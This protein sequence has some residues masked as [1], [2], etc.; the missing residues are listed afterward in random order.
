[1]D[2][3]LMNSDDTFKETATK[4]FASHALRPT[5][6][7]EELPQLR[8]FLEFQAEK[9]ERSNTP[10]NR[11]QSLFDP[12]LLETLTALFSQ[13]TFISATIRDKHGHQVTSPLQRPAIC[14]SLAATSHCVGHAEAMSCMAPNRCFIGRC[15]CGFLVEASAVVQLDGDLIA[16]MALGGVTSMDLDS[17]SS[18]IESTALDSGIDIEDAHRMFEKVV[19]LSPAKVQ[20]AA[21]S[22]L[23]ICQF[24]SE[25]ASVNYAKLQTARAHAVDERTR[26]LLHM[27]G[28]PQG[29][30]ERLH[31]ALFA[32]YRT[33]R[34]RHHTV[35][36]FLMIL[37]C[38][39]PFV[40]G[41]AA[42]S[43]KN[44]LCLAV[45]DW[46]ALLTVPVASSLL[47]PL[48][49]PLLSWG[50]LGLGI[51]LPL[52]VTLTSIKN[53][54]DRI[55]SISRY[56]LRLASRLHVYALL[57]P[58]YST[59]GYYLILLPIYSVVSVSD[60]PPT[61]LIFHCISCAAFVA[62]GTIYN[63][64]HSTAV[65]AP[66]V[67]FTLYPTH[68]VR[69]ALSTMLTQ[70][71]LGA[72][73]RL[74]SLDLN[75]VESEDR[76]TCLMYNAVI[77]VIGMAISLF[78]AVNAFIS[79][80]VDAIGSVVAVGAMASAAV[81]AGLAAVLNI[82]RMPFTSDSVVFAVISLVAGL[83]SSFIVVL[84]IYV[85][86]LRLA[87]CERLVFSVIL[88]E[89][90]ICSRPLS[91][92]KT[93][94]LHPFE[95]RAVLRGLAQAPPPTL[96]Q[97]DLMGLS[98][99]TIELGTRSL[100]SYQRQLALKHLTS[101]S[102]TVPHDNTTGI[103]MAIFK[104]TC[105]IYDVRSTLAL[106]MAM[107]KIG[108]DS[109]ATATAV[110]TRWR[111]MR[112]DH[113]NE[114]TPTN[115][116]LVVGIERH[117]EHMQFVHAFDGEDK[118]AT[119][120]NTQI[121]LAQARE[122]HLRT[123]VRMGKLWPA[124]SGPVNVSI[125]T[126]LVQQVGI[127]ARRANRLYTRL[128]HRYPSEL[129]R[130]WYSLFLDSVMQDHGA[131][132]KLREESV[133]S[134]ASPSIAASS[135]T[136]VSSIGLAGHADSDVSVSLNI[137]R[138]S[139]VTTTIVIVL[140]LLIGSILF[141]L[142]F[143]QQLS[144]SNIETL[145]DASHA[146]HHGTLAALSVRMVDPTPYF[147]DGWG[148]MALAIDRAV[149]T[150]SASSSG[151]QSLMSS[152]DVPTLVVNGHDSSPVSLTVQSSSL[153]T[154]ASTIQSD[155]KIVSR[156]GDDA[157]G[158]APSLSSLAYNG[159]RLA[160][161]AMNAAFSCISSLLRLFQAFSV[162]LFLV[163]LLAELALLT[164]IGVWLSTRVIPQV[165][166]NCDKAIDGFQR[167]TEQQVRRKARLT[168]IACEQFKDI[169][170]TDATPYTA[171][172]EMADI[173]DSAPLDI[174]S[175]HEYG[176]VGGPGSD[177]GDEEGA[178]PPVGGGRRVAFAAVDDEIFVAGPATDT[179]ASDGSDY[180]HVDLYEA[181]SESPGTDPTDLD[182]II[183]ALPDPDQES[184]VVESSGTDTH[185]WS[186]QL[187][188]VRPRARRGKVQGGLRLG[189]NRLSST[190]ARIAHTW[191]AITLVLLVAAV[192][193]GILV[194]AM[195]RHCGSYNEW[196]RRA[197]LVST[198]LVAPLIIGQVEL[199]F[200]AARFVSGSYDSFKMIKPALTEIAID[201][202]LV[203]ADTLPTVGAGDGIA[204]YIELMLARHHPMA[205]AVIMAGHGLGLSAVDVPE[206]TW[207][208]S[209]ETNSASDTE[210]YGRTLWYSDKA[211]DLALNRTQQ[212]AI[213]Q[214]IMYDGKLAGYVT[215]ALEKL[216]ELS[217]AA[218]HAAKAIIGDSLIFDLIVFTSY[219]AVQMVILIAAIVFYNRAATPGP[220]R[221][222]VNVCLALTLGIVA[223]HFLFELS[224]VLIIDVGLDVTFK[225]DSIINRWR[226][227][228]RLLAAVGVM[229]YN[230]QCLIS[231]Q[232]PDLAQDISSSFDSFD[233]IMAS[234]A[235]LDMT[236]PSLAS[237]ASGIR[238]SAGVAARLAL[239]VADAA[240]MTFDGVIWDI[241]TGRS[242]DFGRYSN[243]T[244]DLSLPDADKLD[245]AWNLVLSDP[246]AASDFSQLVTAAEAE[247]A[248]CQDDAAAIL[249]LGSAAVTVNRIAVIFAFTMPVV[250]LSFAV[251]VPAMVF[252][253]APHHRR[254]DPEMNVSIGPFVRITRNALALFFV[255][256][257][258]IF[259]LLLTGNITI[260]RV[261]RDLL[262]MALLDST[263]LAASSQAVVCQTGPALSWHTASITASLAT[264][265]H[266]VPTVVPSPWTDPLGWVGTIGVDF[267]NGPALFMEYSTHTEM[268]TAVDSR[269][270]NA[271]TLTSIA[272]SR[273]A[274]QAMLLVEKLEDSFTA[275]VSVAK[276][277]VMAIRYATVVLVVCLFVA[278]V[279]TFSVL[280]VSQLRK[281]RDF[282]LAF[283]L[284]QTHLPA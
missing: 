229:L 145:H 222:S 267:S 91:I 185:T 192:S 132:Q 152:F 180:G 27:R 172:E 117:I 261:N 244:F 62:I 23:V 231:T 262:G 196:S 271:S 55:T 178:M 25:L 81:T 150:L 36:I 176:P 225:L 173:A 105:D 164:S 277:C 239:S 1:M 44:A 43:T 20:A 95:R 107:L 119:Y 200:Y 112:I 93:I 263:A 15:S 35:A 61:T 223:T 282:V 177:S 163:L 256:L 171:Y 139:I 103:A 274:G 187:L 24:L 7:A 21:E 159:A 264:L 246:V 56:I 135:V 205:V 45:L 64:I 124:L 87:Y 47:S 158:S 31:T 237:F 115:R 226:T 18:L 63:M 82:A 260:M 207:D 90:V 209:A 228:S 273:A 142:T 70:L 270:V 204:E 73:I 77:C 160:L 86:F 242:R 162:L 54:C 218:V 17:A 66:P 278:A 48:V 19:R 193:S 29:W 279:M 5:E 53:G 68:W 236:S 258:P 108:L 259:A 8:R 175:D 161:P 85:S 58:L 100:W 110:T 37:T 195:L 146:I 10:A 240:G 254:H 197:D 186:V 224:Y 9:A 99:L 134:D 174:D 206:F 269:H 138:I 122:Q 202:S 38:V 251:T 114:M 6:L 2:D 149:D 165:M 97:P 221:T 92:L 208:Y 252:G 141:G 227:V 179:D 67:W 214:A 255:T 79:L 59:A 198:D 253:S 275:K 42:A 210:T 30:V 194:F 26:Q 230:T 131:A 157:A 111:E 144:T 98:A 154:L 215:E 127:S 133:G 243:N 12:A 143:L 250:F 283:Q 96:A 188:P 147:P 76:L 191:I 190:K 245:M 49:V 216:S 104:R 199:D 168:M 280:F 14:E 189:I 151:L 4:I 201:R 101:R 34:P 155:F 232:S 52:I 220:L 84:S 211:S 78:L 3:R 129:A 51:L 184:S 235:T 32:P 153:G 130:T 118:A 126:A 46:V 39:A 183:Q 265:G 234:M 182:L 257:L 123:L 106:R 136:S 83:I 88:G 69:V 121:M 167:A 72:A 33:A 213:A 50:F 125:V 80:P 181:G 238:H 11:I 74:A 71:I 169:T 156:N 13:H 219:Q 41:L 137:P 94:I 16:T 170:L 148:D 247:L 75:G 266:A 276:Y 241:S 217:N 248:S 89:D 281:L 268:F 249:R 212:L 40:A 233:G 109:P 22:C 166:F 102:R 60:F 116:M 57:V 65:T 272:H 28:A 203:V 140:Q 284:I 120:L 113:F 128:L